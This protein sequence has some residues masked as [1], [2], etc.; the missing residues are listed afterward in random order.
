MPAPGRYSTA[1]PEAQQ[2]YP[3]AGPVYPDVA[4]TTEEPYYP[5]PAEG[6]VRR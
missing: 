6:E 2:E 5:P 3:S 1:E 4:P